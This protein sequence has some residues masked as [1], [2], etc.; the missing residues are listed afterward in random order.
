MAVNRDILT[1]SLV[2][3]GISLADLVEA[4]IRSAGL[5]IE[6]VWRNPETLPVDLP[7]RPDLVRRI[8]LLR[9]VNDSL[10][11]SGPDNTFSGLTSSLGNELQIRRLPVPTP[12]KPGVLTGVVLPADLN[13]RASLRFI[14]QLHPVDPQ[15]ALDD[16]KAF[17][18]RRLGLG[19]TELGRHF[20]LE[21][22]LRPA[23][24]EPQPVPSP[25]DHP[26]QIPPSI[27]GLQKEV[28]IFC[29]QL[30]T[31]TQAQIEAALDKTP[32]DSPFAQDIA[33][34]ATDDKTGSEVLSERVTTQ[35][36]R[37]LATAG[38]SDDAQAVVIR[39]VTKA[40][41]EGGFEPDAAAKVTSTTLSRLGAAGEK[42]RI[43]QVATA[44]RIN[45]YISSRNAY[46]Q[47]SRTLVDAISDATNQALNQTGLSLNAD[48]EKAI[49]TAVYR[50]ISGLLSFDQIVPDT[51]LSEIT[52]QVKDQVSE[53]VSGAYSIT[54]K[55]GGKRVG[56]FDKATSEILYK[57]LGELTANF[58]DEVSTSLRTLTAIH[59]SDAQTLAVHSIRP[60]FVQAAAKTEEEVVLF[61]VNEFIRDLTPQISRAADRQIL[62]ENAPIVAESLVR[63]L[64]QVG[65]RERMYL[66]AH[67]GVQLRNV[68]SA[69]MT[70]VED[71]ASSK[72]DRDTKA[73]VVNNIP[74][75]LVET[76]KTV[77]LSSELGVGG[78]GQAVE[79]FRIEAENL[80]GSTVAELPIRLPNQVVKYVHQ[81]ARLAADSVLITLNNQYCLDKYQTLA[82][83]RRLISQALVYG[84]AQALPPQIN[85]ALQHNL[86]TKLNRD[87][88]Q[89]LTNLAH[90]ATTYL[91]LLPS[92][93]EIF[94]QRAIDR[95]AAAFEDYLISNTPLSG[96]ALKQEAIYLTGLY[97]N[98]LIQ[99]IVGG[100]ILW[101]PNFKQALTSALTQTLQT[102]N[103]L[104]TTPTPGPPGVAPPP[105]PTPKYTQQLINQVASWL[106]QNPGFLGAAANATI[107]IPPAP[108]Q[109]SGGQPTGIPVQGQAFEF[110]YHL[111]TNP[112]G[113]LPYAINKL[114]VPIELL[115]DRGAEAISQ[116]PRLYTPIVNILIAQGVWTPRAALAYSQIAIQYA[117]KTYTI[118]D[119][120]RSIDHLLGLRKM[121]GVDKPKKPLNPNDPI[122]IHFRNVISGLEA[123]NQTGL[124]RIINF[125]NRIETAARRQAE[126]LQIL[127]GARKV[128]LW[129]TEY[130]LRVVTE[131]LAKHYFRKGI[132]NTYRKTIGRGLNKLGLRLGL[133]EE[134]PSPLGFQKIKFVG[135]KLLWRGVRK[136]AR[137]AYAFFLVKFLKK[138]AR[139]LVH[140]IVKKV[141]QKI[142]TTVATIMTGIGTVF[143]AF[144]LVWDRV[145][146]I[147]KLALLYLLF[148]ILTHGLPALLG[149][150]AG[151]AAGIVLAFKVF[152]ATLA[153][154]SFLGPF[155]VIPAF[156]A[157]LTVIIAST[158]FGA[159]LGVFV[160]NLL[161]GIQLIAH[162]F[163][164]AA[165]GA[166][167]SAFGSAVSA[168]GS[169]W[170]GIS[171]ILTAGW[172]AFVTGLGSIA[173]SGITL[174]AIGFLGTISSLTLLVVATIM[175]AFSQPA[176][177]GGPVAPSERYAGCIVKDIHD[178]NS[179]DDSELAAGIVY[180]SDRYPTL[181]EEINTDQG[182]E[183]AIDFIVRKAKNAGWNP[184]FVVAIWGEESHFSNY[185][186]VTTGGAV[187]TEGAD[188]G[189]GIGVLGDGSPVCANEPKDLQQSVACFIGTHASCNQKCGDRA[190]FNDFMQCY[191][192]VSP[193]FKS[194][195]IQI[196]KTFDPDGYECAGPGGGFSV[197]LADA[198]AQ[199][200]CGRDSAENGCAATNP[201]NI[202]RTN[203]L[204]S[205]DK[206]VKTAILSCL[207][208]KGI[209]Q[210]AIEQ[211]R[212][213]VANQV[214]LQCV[215]LARAVEA[216]SGSNLPAPNG[217]KA[218]GYLEKTPTG[219]SYTKG[220][221]TSQAGDLLLFNDNYCTACTAGS[222]AVVN[223]ISGDPG[224][225]VLVLTHANLNGQGC[226]TTTDRHT[227]D[228]PGLQGYLRRTI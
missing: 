38:E 31:H 116:D 216:G 213:S 160:A 184:A 6:T 83:S 24:P 115:A 206:S 168:L 48:Q 202:D 170:G 89:H 47:A 96:V 142:I 155:A 67:M 143:T 20:Q 128:F 11:N 57:S 145:K 34:L 219:Y 51:P 108:T 197:Q 5:E 193:N 191:G 117:A 222:I 127:W 136:V 16:L 111:L 110:L 43:N 224:Y 129:Q 144:R 166:L 176:G 100:S 141:V 55:K 181:I 133:Y 112:F 175:T 94:T 44:Q 80:V 76:G 169:L 63:R 73:L 195:V 106:N 7:D 125:H 68:L 105:A 36:E 153:L 203:F 65:E 201:C 37:A 134:A 102:A 79:K 194:N 1:D 62:V 81:T 97:I 14:G 211:V 92:P 86:L 50:S 103:Q 179:M 174:L 146:K 53:A 87:E 221:L 135:H 61:K 49:H 66:Y 196:Y 172:S 120:Q 9:Q 157:S 138:P 10:G 35:V 214:Q 123:L 104:Q 82:L 39:T 156:L 165:S 178:V 198:L 208:T 21:E 41:T 192:P 217:E 40:L 101:G 88:D 130:T 91:T 149:G 173:V 171:G 118:Q 90:H 4:K 210:P 15:G 227:K 25:K 150:L 13:P 124:G 158:I 199:C 152:A 159:H 12:I 78:L 122:I 163:I 189:C 42:A 3:I 93:D 161:G 200:V 148:Y 131:S 8:V 72:L 107:I 71:K 74:E 164:T 154:F 22:P 27:A 33:A 56:L 52:A 162:Q 177:L 147:F 70:E 188:L 185:G 205:T 32:P 137:K 59:A 85:Q 58:G 98:Q 228:T 30:T 225:P 215:G 29:D 95:L 151:L 109:T 209:P 204:N 77:L 126:P 113:L 218:K 226:V 187:V 75:E 183:R 69:I 46:I 17:I 139:L 23:G 26:P 28:T 182:P 45:N 114:M 180:W 54:L 99:Q 207:V 220:V 132:L 64:K 167:S 190:D 121:P 2:Q 19:V 60:T 18:T 186:E 140:K 223:S 84:L 212:S 119:L